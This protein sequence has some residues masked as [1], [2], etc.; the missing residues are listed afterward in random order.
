MKYKVGDKVK[1]KTWK[2]M[3]KEFGLNYYKDVKCDGRCFMKYMEEA[4]K[5]MD[6]NRIVIIEGIKDDY[7]GDDYI[8]KGFRKYYQT[9]DYEWRWRDNMIKCE[10]SHK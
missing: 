1:I 5:D 2:E 8:M 4:I 10:Y 7:I 3:E 6:A 9:D